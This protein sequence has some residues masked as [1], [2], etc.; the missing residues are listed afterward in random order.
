MYIRFFN[1]FTI[2]IIGS[3]G[4]KLLTSMFLEYYDAKILHDLSEVETP[5]LYIFLGSR[6]PKDTEESSKLL[7]PENSNVPVLISILSKKDYEFVTI[8]CK[9]NNL[10]LY[11]APLKKIISMYKYLNFPFF[12]YIHLSLAA[13]ASKLSKE[14]FLTPSKQKVPLMSLIN[15]I[16]KDINDT[17]GNK[18]VGDSLNESLELIG[19]SPEKSFHIRSYTKDSVEFVWEPGTYDLGNRL[20]MEWLRNNKNKPV[21]TII[22]IDGIP[23][24]FSEIKDY[25]LPFTTLGIKQK[26]FL[27]INSEEVNN[28]Q[29]EES[30]P[31]VPFDYHVY[32]KLMELWN[33][34]HYI[35]K[36]KALLD[37]IPG[38]METIVSDTIINFDP[39]FEESIV[40]PPIFII[41]FSDSIK[42]FISKIS[43]CIVLYIGKEENYKNII[44]E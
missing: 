29:N 43:N 24:G 21:Y 39:N 3:P 31:S 22:D 17:E 34:K 44:K 13:C 42:N 16:V 8:F 30:E 11:I 26:G 40:K 35:P 33:N 5:N 23:S 36:R 15:P 32:T 25:L 4:K 12:D 7:D 37:P 9:K 20:L 41:D 1:G 28:D 19:V 6:T 38:Y 14:N 27:I 18:D 10:R 2:K